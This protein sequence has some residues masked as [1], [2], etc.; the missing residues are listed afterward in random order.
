MRTFFPLI[1]LVLAAIIPAC[2]CSSGSD[3][4]TADPPAASSA[5]SLRVHSAHRLMN[6]NLRIP[7]GRMQINSAG[8]RM[9]R[10]APGVVPHASA[11]AS[12]H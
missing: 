8:L 4:P 11:S 9:L 5:A 10:T 12:A 7:T 2:T 6:P 1:A 3:T